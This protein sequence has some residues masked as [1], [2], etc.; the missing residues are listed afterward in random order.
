MIRRILLFA[1]FAIFVSN[2]IAADSYHIKIKIN[3][4]EEKELLLAYHLGDKQYIR[5]TVEIDGNGFFHFQGDEP[6]DCGIYLVVLKPDNNYFQLI[7]NEQ[8]QDIT[9]ITD[10]QDLVGKASIKGSED[11][12]LFFD[13]LNYLN[14]RTPEANSLNKSLEETT[15]DNEKQKIQGQLDDLNKKVE[16][17]QKNIVEKH[18]GTLTAQIIKST[19]RVDMPEFDGSQEEV[20]MKQWRYMQKHY[21]DNLDLENSC[22]LRTPFLFQRVDYFVNK[23]QVQHPDTIFKAIE[24]VVDAMEPAE[25]TYKFY[26]IHFLNEYATSKIV[27][28]DAVY[29][30]IAEKYYATG[31]APWVD[32]EQLEKILQNVKDIKPTLIGKPAPDLLLQKREG[33]MVKLSEIESEYTVLYF[34]RFD[35]GHCKKSSP[36]LKE[37]YEK[38]K[39][40]NVKLV[41]VCSKQKDELP[42]CWK[43]VDENEIQDWM[44]TSDPYFR[45]MKLYN[46]KSTPQIFV[47]DKNKEILTKKIG[48]EQLEEVMNKIIEMDAKEALDNE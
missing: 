28:M 6:M 20:Q 34:W 41:A 22:M 30:Q 24:R 33:G 18:P 5:D 2:I 13:Y 23:L 31:K 8:E 11:N 46:I 36:M 43:Y 48:A 17:Y 15:D 29:V 21:F 37:F 7:V 32:E 44:H 14:A 42:E 40:R 10:V 47:L 3:G 1:V 4:Y 39:D 9:L 19:F 38:F 25:E 27:G 26:V 45:S 16:A 35:C 12:Q